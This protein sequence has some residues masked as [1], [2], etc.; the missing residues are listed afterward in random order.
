M[1]GDADVRPWLDRLAY[2]MRL[3]EGCLEDCSRI[4]FRLKS[5]SG[6]SCF[7]PREDW[8]LWDHGNVRVWFHNAKPDVVCEVDNSQG[9]DSEIINMWYALHPVY[10]GGIRSGG[11]PLHAALIGRKGGAVI[12]AGPSGTGKS[13][14]CR[15]VVPPW[16]ALCDDV[17]LIVRGEKG[18]Y[19]AHPFP[20]WSD[21]LWHRA[22]NRWN[23][24]DSVP[25]RAVFFISHA[26]TEACRPMVKAMA[27]CRVSGSA[28]QVCEKFWQ[29]RDGEPRRV[30]TNGIFSNACEIVKTIPAFELGVSQ[31]GKFWEEIERAIEGL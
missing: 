10:L 18:E 30:L 6:L 17:A 13:T 2:I 1:S 11:L 3:E 15:R 4:H 7:T 22:E 8:T 19:R 21:Y 25:L 27:A 31:H 24:Q 9:H 29:K 23:V 26:E 20:T 16:R 14:C 28:A 5:E 12:L